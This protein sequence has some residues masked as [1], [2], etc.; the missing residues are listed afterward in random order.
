MSSKPGRSVGRVNPQLCPAGQKGEEEGTAAAAAACFLFSD[1]QICRERSLPPPPFGT[2]P[3]SCACQ[4][5]ADGRRK[6]G[7]GEEGDI[8]DSAGELIKQKSKNLYHSGV[9]R[10]EGERTNGTFLVE[11]CTQAASQKREEGG[12]GGQISIFSGRGRKGTFFVGWN[13]RL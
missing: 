9:G 8:A 5:Q 1:H 6:E 7:G 4:L 2:R 3:L 10:R 13:E 11:H 12:K